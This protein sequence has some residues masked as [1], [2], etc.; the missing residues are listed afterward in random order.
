MNN[1]SNHIIDQAIQ[2]IL[3][4]TPHLKKISLREDTYRKVNIL[5]TKQ[6]ELICVKFNYFSLYYSSRKSNFFEKTSTTA[7]ESLI[8]CITLK[9]LVFKQI[10]NTDGTDILLKNILLNNNNWRN[11]KRLEISGI[12]ISSDQELTKFSQNF[13][14]LKRL[15]VSFSNITDFTILGKNCPH[16]KSLV[17]C[18]NK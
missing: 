12:T 6:T 17:F 4:N 13:P 15:S 3:D 7:I 18:T 8:T 16:I 5:F 11:I 10:S 9:T 14:K 1:E 2:K